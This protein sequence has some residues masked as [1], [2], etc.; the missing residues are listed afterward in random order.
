MGGRELLVI[1]TLFRGPGIRSFIN[2]SDWH[3]AVCAFPLVSRPRPSPRGSVAAILIGCN[4]H[5]PKFAGQN[6]RSVRYHPSQIVASSL[7][8]VGGVEVQVSRG[9]TPTRSRIAGSLRN[10]L[11]WTLRLWVKSNYRRV[12]PRQILRMQCN[13]ASKVVQVLGS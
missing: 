6:I 7:A 9:M 10:R 5:R 13:L 2:L 11:W 1:R 8:E 3:V 12:L 4:M